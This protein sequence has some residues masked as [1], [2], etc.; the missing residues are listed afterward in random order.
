MGVFSILDIQDFGTLNP[1]VRGGG[2][3]RKTVG[4]SIKRDLEVNGLSLD[5]INDRTLWC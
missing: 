2:R 1:L 5:L 3:S 4:Q